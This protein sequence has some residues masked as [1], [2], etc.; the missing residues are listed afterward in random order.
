M[1]LRRHQEFNYP[2]PVIVILGKSVLPVPREGAGDPVGGG[3][4]PVGGDGDGWP[5]DGDW[6]VGGAVGGNVEPAKE[7][8]IGHIRSTSKTSQIYIHRRP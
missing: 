5:V 7:L 6:V 4:D 1:E 8:T 3:G 2:P